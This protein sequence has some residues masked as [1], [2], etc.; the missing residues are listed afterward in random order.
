M[1]I[2]TKAEFIDRI[3]NKLGFPVIKINVDDAHYELAITEAIEKF[4]DYH[5]DGQKKVYI[6]GTLTETDIINNYITT[7]DNVIEVI[8]LIPAGSGAWTRDITSWSYQYSHYY[9]NEVTRTNCYITLTDWALYKNRFN[10]LTYVF[11]V[12]NVPF[13]FVKYQHR[14]RL[15]NDVVAGEEIVYEAI[16]RVDPNDA[17]SEWAWNDRWLLEYATT[18]VKEYWGSI[19]QKAEGIQLVGG[20]T[21]NGEL[22]YNQAQEDKRRLEE[23]VEQGHQEPP[24]FYIG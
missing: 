22:I 20:I 21:L 19:L 8:Q 18:L 24:K 7:P 9:L 10:T 2:N 5:R 23:E 17:G 4:N 13:E 12:D 15:D 16:E 1:A 11:G 14:L 3:K 6:I